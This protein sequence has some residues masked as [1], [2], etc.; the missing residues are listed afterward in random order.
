MFIL[1]N[2]KISEILNEVCNPELQWKLLTP[3]SDFENTYQ[4]LI[5]NQQ[6][7]SRD[8]CRT[9]YPI[10]ENQEIPE[11]HLLKKSFN[12]IK[13]TKN[14]LGHTG[15]FGKI[16]LWRVNPAGKVN[17]HTDTWK[18][19]FKIKRYMIN[20]NMDPLLCD[21]IVNEGKIDFPI[22][23]I[24]CLPLTIKHKIDTRMHVPAYFLNFDTYISTTT[25]EEY[26]SQGG[27]ELFYH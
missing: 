10:M 14:D 15:I 5:N 25:Y 21:L 24:Y 4:V 19:H 8:N 2:E 17:Y 20:V 16:S 6:C 3:I 11:D 1:P 13:D 9:L 18:Y 7:S 27:E 26:L 22:G 23:G 12:I